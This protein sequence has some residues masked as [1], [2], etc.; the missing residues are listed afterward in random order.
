MQFWVEEESPSVT[1]KR[2][3]LHSGQFQVY[4]FGD[5]E[6]DDAERLR[7]FAREKGIDWA[8]VHFNSPGGSVFGGLELGEAIRALKF[9]TGVGSG[10]HLA[11]ERVSAICASAAA[12]AFAGGINRFFEGDEGLLGIHR[13]YGDQALSAD[14]SQIISGMIVSYLRRM[15]VDPT[16]FSLACEADA[17]GMVWLSG[18]DAQELGFANNGTHPTTSEIKVNKGTHYLKLEQRHHNVTSRVLLFAEG[19]EFE[20]LAG[21]VT[22]QQAALEHSVALRSYL[23]IDGQRALCVE[24][25]GVSADDCTIWLE[26]TLDYQTVRRISEAN[27]VEIWTENGGPFRWG[28][29]MDISPVREKLFDFVENCSAS[30]DARG[31]NE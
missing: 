22:S 13:F 23:E 10:P 30:R 25:G 24:G 5:V 31:R 15:G 16:V 28:T 3:F 8:R 14:T 27:V 1:M 2:H 11:G 12:Y 21:I 4:A 7:V 18:A 29:T 17:N 9:D 19:G 26:R 6:D 20:M